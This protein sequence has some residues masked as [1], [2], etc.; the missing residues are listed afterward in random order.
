MVAGIQAKSGKADQRHQEGGEVETRTH[1]RNRE[2]N[3]ADPSGNEALVPIIVTVPLDKLVDKKKRMKNQ[4]EIR[5]RSAEQR[6]RTGRTEEKRNMSFSLPFTVT[7]SAFI[8]GPR[9]TT[10][11]AQI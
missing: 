8:P 10:G 1:E 4:R 5:G 7:Y 2:K 3:L 11:H 6:R 9:I